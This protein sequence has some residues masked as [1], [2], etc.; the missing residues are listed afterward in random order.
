MKKHI[1][2]AVNNRGVEELLNNFKY[3]TEK[4]SFHIRKMSDSD[5]PHVLELENKSFPDPW[6]EKAFQGEI[7]NISGASYAFICETSNKLAGYFC[8]WKIV[9]EIHITNIVVESSF[10]NMGLGQAL[11]GFIIDF[12]RVLQCRTVTLEVR[13]SNIAARKLYEKSGFGYSGIRKNY[14]R[15][16]GEDGLIMTLKIEE[17]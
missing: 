12:G 11:V 4:K 2:S 7:E 3:S 9:D 15:E 17:I 1:E 5:I 6:G 13:P 8:L 16:S 14:Y 10:Q